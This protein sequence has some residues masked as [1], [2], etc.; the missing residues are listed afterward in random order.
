M[1]ICTVDKNLLGEFARS[2]A[3]C[4][5]GLPFLAAVS[6]RLLRADISA[7]SLME[8]TPFKRIRKNIMAISKIGGLS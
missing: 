7:I 5:L 8:K 2:S 1:P 6:R 3:A 4:A